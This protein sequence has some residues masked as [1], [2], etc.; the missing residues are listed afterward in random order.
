MRE[1]EF[2]RVLGVSR[3]R[4]RWLRRGLTEGTH[5]ARSGRAVVWTE[6]G[7]VAAREAIA[8]ELA[9]PAIVDGTNRANGTDGAEKV[10]DIELAH[11][12]VLRRVINPHIV[13][14]IEVGAGE[15]VQRVR[16]RSSENF[17]PGMTLRAR[18]VEADLWELAGRCPRWKGRW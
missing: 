11:L 14:A 4:L 18:R 7:Q 3:E 13:L 15:A 10:P 8:R 12:R 17:I 1:A 16:V 2:C 9:V 5:F 6:A